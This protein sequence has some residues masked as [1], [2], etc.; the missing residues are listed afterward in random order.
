MIGQKSE[1]NIPLMV[2]GE[3]RYGFL[4]GSKQSDNETKLSRFLAQPHIQIL[5]PGSATTGHYAELCQ[6]AAR[7]GR[8][9][10]HNDLWIAAL[11][12]EHGHSIATLDKD[13]AVFEPL[14]GTRLHIFAT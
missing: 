7:R 8:A 13:F 11:A 12:Q 14:M 1:L 3:L 10:S 5:L 2:I 4:G 6:Y 9:L